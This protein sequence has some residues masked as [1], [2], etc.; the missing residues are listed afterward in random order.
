MT[1]K[2][3]KSIPARITRR[4]AMAPLRLIG[5]RM[6]AEA[7]EALSAAMVVEAPIPSGALKFFAPSPL[8]QLRAENVLT[9]EP[10][11]IRWIDG[12]AKDDVLWDIG[13]NVGVFSLYAAVRTTCTVLSFEPSAANY[14]VLARNIQLNRLNDQVTAYCVALSGATELGVLNLSAASMGAAVCQ[15]GKFGEMSR[16]WTGES[17]GA[18]QGMLGF[19]IDD[20]IAL[21]NPPFPTHIKV[22]VDGLEWPILQGATKTLC[23]LRLEAVMVELSLT[24]NKERECAMALLERS[25]LKHVGCGVA[26]GTSAEKAAN[27]LFARL[28]R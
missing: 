6:R 23:D 25:G 3:L 10:D 2:R 12:M 27:H 16:Y 9:K 21:F 26:Q 22:D 8:L 17:E 18:A 7:I 14:F 19:T 24:D 11:M 4:L 5:G 1:L 20:F 13:A 28:Q 15:F